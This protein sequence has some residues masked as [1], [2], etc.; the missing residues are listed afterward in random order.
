MLVLT[1][2]I[3]EELWI[4]NARVVINRL[5]DGKVSLAIDAPRDVLIVRSE[6]LNKPRGTNEQDPSQSETNLD[7][8]CG[9]TGRPNDHGPESNPTM[10]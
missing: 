9:E 3:N 4:G 8:S 5:A 7:P 10:D 1:R 6:L 2:K